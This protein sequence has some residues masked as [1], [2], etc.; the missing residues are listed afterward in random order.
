MSSNVTHI[1]TPFKIG[2]LTLPNRL[3]QGPLAGY[4]CAPF[5][6]LFYRYTP[7]AY[8]VTEMISS[9]DVLH[10]HQP[11]SRYLYRAPE[12]ERLCYQLS[13]HDPKILAAS[14]V[15][16]QTLGADLIDLNAGCPK[17]KIRK[18]NAGSALLDDPERLLAIIQAVRSVITIPFT[19]KIRIK[20][21]ARDIDLAKGIEQSGADAVIVHGRRWTDDYDVLA[22]FAQ[23]ARIKQAVSIPVIANGDIADSSS[24][25]HAMN[26]T[27]CDA[28]MIARAGCGK[29]WLYQQLLSDS[30]SVIPVNFAERVDCFMMHLEG[31]ARLESEHQ[32]VLQSKSLVR[33]YFK[34][35]FSESRLNA[36]YR[37]DSLLAIKACMLEQMN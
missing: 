23:I 29:P 32:A 22:D 26:N 27:G 8:C 24:L 14:A 13:G 5:R 6:Q 21:D 35:V 16:I 17:T 31:L 28:Y 7:P 15:R 10:K 2:S 33:Y 19:V 12:E 1:N 4:S 34:D 11:D 20:G 36:F 30:D 9:Q 18:K 25:R 3:I 37:L